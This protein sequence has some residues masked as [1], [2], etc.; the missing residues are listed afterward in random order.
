MELFWGT[1]SCSEGD[2]L[3]EQFCWIASWILGNQEQ[4]WWIPSWILEDQELFW[5]ALLLH[6]KLDFGGS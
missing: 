5:G 2:L 3:V 6:H 4:F 1:T